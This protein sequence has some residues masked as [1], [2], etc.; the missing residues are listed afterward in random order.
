MTDTG[1]QVT[2]TLCQQRFSPGAPGSTVRV[3]DHG[4]QHYCPM[5]WSG[6]SWSDYRKPKKPKPSLLKI[7]IVIF[8]CLIALSFWGQFLYGL[9][10]TF[11]DAI[12]DIILWVGAG[13]AVVVAWRFLYR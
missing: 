12:L 5:C 7:F 13:F 10:G 1:D 2:C 3:D 11:P 8:V 4:E 9:G 6:Q